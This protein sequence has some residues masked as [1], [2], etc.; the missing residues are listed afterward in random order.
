MLHYTVC[1][2]TMHFRKTCKLDINFPMPFILSHVQYLTT[3]RHILHNLMVVFVFCFI[4][5]LFW[6]GGANGG[7]MDADCRVKL[8][9]CLVH[10]ITSCTPHK[11]ALMNCIIIWARHYTSNSFSQ[12]TQKWASVKWP[13]SSPLPFTHTHTH[14]ISTPHLLR[15]RELEWKTYST[16]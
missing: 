7:Y 9:E 12:Y 2:T 14:S 5:M 15:E 16:V 8:V 6:F 11:V 10:L 13:A 3:Y 4:L 1:I